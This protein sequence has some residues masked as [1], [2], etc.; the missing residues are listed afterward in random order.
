MLKIGDRVKFL[1]QTGVGII[2][3]IERDIV[4]VDV[5]DGFEVPAQ[6]TDIISVSKEQ[7]L[8]ALA[9]FGEGD[10]RPGTKKGKP[11]PNQ[12][13]VIKK[14]REVYRRYGKVTLVNDEDMEDDED[15]IDLFDIKERYL[16]NLLAKQRL[17]REIEEEE[18]KRG[19][20]KERT[21]ESSPINVVI[22]DVF[23]D[24]STPSASKDKLKTVTLEQLA[25]IDKP[26]KKTLKDYLK[27]K[28][29]LQQTEEPEID[30]IDLHAEEIL[31]SLEG[32]TDRK[33]VV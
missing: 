28:S 21:I 3:K 8:E 10:K 9:S 6:I 24:K 11:K 25:K 30:V 4:W 16:K 32:I 29:K 2:T 17:E 7:E 26:E 15:I 19:L 20:A 18:L 23:M 14:E 27:P 1:S 5:E 13:K 12:P 31:D 33:S 22:E